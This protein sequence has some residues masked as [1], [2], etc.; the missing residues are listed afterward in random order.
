MD[1]YGT[2]MVTGIVSNYAIAM[3][4]SC[5]ITISSYLSGPSADLFLIKKPAPGRGFTIG[6]TTSNQDFRIL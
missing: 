2:I 3:A 5:S 4:I 6:V 1:D